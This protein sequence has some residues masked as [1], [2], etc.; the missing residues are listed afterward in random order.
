MKFVATL[1]GVAVAILG[2]I[3]FLVSDVAPIGLAFLLTGICLVML[4]LTREE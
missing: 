3:W 4:S 2:L 1:I